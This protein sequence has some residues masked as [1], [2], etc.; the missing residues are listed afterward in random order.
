[1]Y[2]DDGYYHI[3]DHLDRCVHGSALQCSAWF[4]PVGT[5]MSP[6]LELGEAS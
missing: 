3:H 6:S 4:G 5:R 2:Y 1:M